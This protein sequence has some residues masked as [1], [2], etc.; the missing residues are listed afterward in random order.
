VDLQ[1]VAVRNYVGPQLDTELALAV[2]AVRRELPRFCELWNLPVPGIAYYGA[3]HDGAMDEEAVIPVIASSGD[4]TAFARHGALG[5]A[6]Y[7]YVDADL[8]AAEAEPIPRALSHEVFEM[9]ADPLLDRSEPLPDGTSI[10]RE[11]C[12]PVNRLGFALE[13]E[14]FGRVGV[15]PVSDYVLPSYFIVGSRGPWDRAGLLAGPISPAERGHVL[16]AQAGSV[17]LRA[18]AGGA[19]VVAH[20]RTSRRLAAGR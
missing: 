3:S 2:A 1:H 12:D 10:L 20:G 19:R 4:P 13:A 15:V 5:M 11:V 6:V 17:V 18:G 8:C 9:V 16:V 14:F 7:G